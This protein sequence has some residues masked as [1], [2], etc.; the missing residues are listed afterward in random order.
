M[1]RLAVVRHGKS[2]G[3]LDESMYTE[4][5]AAICLTPKGVKQIIQAAHLIKPFFH[6]YGHGAYISAYCSKLFRAWHSARILLDTMGFQKV[7]PIQDG[8]LNE[9]HYGEYLAG[10]LPDEHKRALDFAPNGGESMRDIHAR[11]VPWFQNTIMPLLAFNDVLLVTHHNTSQALLGH[12]RGV[13]IEEITE[14]DV[15]N[16]RP[17]VFQVDPLPARQIREVEIPWHVPAEWS[18]I[19]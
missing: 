6:P 1:N 5:E 2:T 13:R 19:S 3:N 14:I 7:E 9:R 10:R 8:H 15:L 11:V 18:E 12:L 16:G 17:H 4:C